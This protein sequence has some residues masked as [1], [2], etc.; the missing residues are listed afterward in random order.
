[1]AQAGA[2][3]LGMLTRAVQDGRLRRIVQMVESGSPCTIRGLALEC[4]L[5][6]SH[7]QHLFKQQTGVGLGHWLTGQRLERAA[8]LLAHS[9]MSIKEIAYTVGYEHTSSFIRAFERRFTQAPRCYR[10]QGDRTKC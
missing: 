4:N 5:S 1:M 6:P 9:N 7:L 10:Q 2:A 8:H 3:G